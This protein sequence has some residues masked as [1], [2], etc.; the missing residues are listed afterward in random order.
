MSDDEPPGL[1]SVYDGG[2]HQWSAARVR[3]SWE[4]A[5]YPPVPLGLAINFDD[6]TLVLPANSTQEMQPFDR[7]PGFALRKAQMRADGMLMDTD[8]PSLM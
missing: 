5:G 6:T 4:G 3:M 8:L 2:P 7:A 1:V